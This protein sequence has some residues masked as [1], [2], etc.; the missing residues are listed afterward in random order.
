VA[1]AWQSFSLAVIK[2]SSRSA[3]DAG[4]EPC[5]AH[6]HK[7][8]A[9][10]ECVAANLSQ[11]HEG[12]SQVLLWWDPQMGATPRNRYHLLG[13]EHLLRTVRAACWICGLELASAQDTCGLVSQ[14]CYHAWHA[15]AADPHR[16]GGLPGSLA[17]SNEMLCCSRPAQHAWVAC[18][19][20]VQYCD[21]VRPQAVYFSAWA[22]RL[23]VA[24]HLF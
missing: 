21:L 24:L 22:L 11:G 17:P 4:L 10:T 9:Q 7:P 3:R 18:H 14:S 8:V 6:R 1:Y 19:T 12:T 23:S 13:W 20:G 15:A 2:P 16:P 5:T